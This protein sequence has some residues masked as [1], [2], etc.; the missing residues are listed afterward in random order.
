M[1][2]ATR[3]FALEAGGNELQ[4]VSGR[5]RPVDVAGRDLDLDLR[6]EQRRPL[7]VAVRWSL[8]G[9][10]PQGALE[11]VS[12]RGG[13]RGHVALGQTHQREA[14]L[15]IPPGAMGAQ[16][17]FLGAGDVSL[18][19]SDPPQLVQRPPQLAPQVRA[20]F[21]ASRQCL[22]L[23]LVAR[24]AQPEDLGAM[25]PATS[26]KA[27]D[28]IRLAP[29]LHRLGP[30]LSHVIHGE[31]LQGA[32]QLAVD[33]PCRQR[34][35]IA[36]NRRH[37]SFVEQCQTLGHVPVQ[38][39]QPGFGDPSNGACRRVTR[40]TH[41]DRTPGPLPGAGRV[42][43]QHPLIAAHDRQPGVRRCLG[44]TFEKPLGSCQPAAHRC[45]QCRVE[46][47]VHRHANG[48]TGGRDVVTGLEA[49]RVGPLPRLDGHIEM[50]GGIGHLAEQRQIGGGQGADHVRLHEEVEC[51]LPGSPRCRVTCP[52]D[53]AATGSIA[54]RTPPQ[55][56][57]DRSRG[58]PAPNVTV[59]VTA[60]PVLLAVT[61]S[62]LIDTDDPEDEPHG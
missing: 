21:L 17:G 59:R 56:M 37:P 44:L 3:R 5:P 13:R 23:R 27:A 1:A 34:I 46:Q 52:L 36:R 49:C 11:G 35:E 7:Q 15:R 9:W 14:R 61:G 62:A 30:L 47:H 39:E 28:G 8:L 29:P 41:L 42:A 6:L 22:T 51:L 20:Q 57:T 25:H 38:D 16:Q 10:H 54:H 2:L 48:R 12:Y 50:A 53:D 43:R 4:L 24:P 31:A 58:Q 18:V 26:V 19:Q 60:V 55:S 33:D 45:H 40:R 32:H